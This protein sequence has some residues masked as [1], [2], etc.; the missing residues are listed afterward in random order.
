[1]KSNT[2]L[3]YESIHA[4][5]TSY[6]TLASEYYDEDK[7]PTCADFRAAAR[8]YLKGLFNIDPPRGLMADIGCGRSLLAEFDASVALFDSSRAML[9]LNPPNLQLHL[10]DIE[11]TSFGNSEFDWVFAVL[12]DPFNNLHAWQHIARALKPGGK[13]VFIVPSYAWAKK[14]RSINPHEKENFAA[15]LSAG[16]LVYVPSTILP[17]KQQSDLIRRAG[18]RFDLV[19]DLPRGRLPIIR[20]EKIARFLSKNDSI[21]DIYTA[22]KEKSH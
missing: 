8:S 2:R 13:C 5:A 17:H 18:L 1:V 22:T 21:L 6:E 3:A 12:G 7:H 19:E 16:T 20:S 15:F 14:F 4:D 11:Q 10:I 9:S